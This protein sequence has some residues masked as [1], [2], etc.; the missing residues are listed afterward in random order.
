MSYI[1]PFTQFEYVQYT[2]R[3][4]SA[5]SMRKNGITGLKAVQPI[6]F[7][8]RNENGVTHT[9][10]NKEDLIYPMSGLNTGS[11]SHRIPEALVNQTM[12]DL[13]GVGK[14]INLSI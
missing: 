12:S 8:R 9:E 13:A 2:N 6:L 1:M 7:L 10:E 5:E 14:F 3:T 4:V 11:R